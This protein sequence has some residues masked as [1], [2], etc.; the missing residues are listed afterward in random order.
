MEQLSPVPP[1]AMMKARRSKKRAI[2]A[3]LKWGEGWSR[4]SIYFVQDCNLGQYKMEQLSPIPPKAMMKARRS[5][6]RAILASLKWGEGWSRCSI[7]FVQDCNLGQYKMEQLSP[8]P[9]KAMMNARRS[10]KRAI[11]ASLKWGEGWSRCSIILS[12][13]V[14]RSRYFFLR[15]KQNSPI[16]SHARA[17]I[18]E[19][20]VITQLVL[21]TN[22]SDRS[23]NF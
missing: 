6:K 18:K 10:K 2:L 20:T 3:S 4:C 15:R 14:G 5:K 23:R 11:L 21:V 17:T 19:C 16:T 9:P 1:K 13:I 7:Y 8:I 22:K 12:K